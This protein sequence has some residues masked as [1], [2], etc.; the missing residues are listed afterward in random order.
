MEEQQ[1]KTPQ[2]VIKNKGNVIKTRDDRE[3]ILIDFNG[4]VV[5]PEK[6][7]WTPNDGETVSNSVFRSRIEPWLTSLFQSEHLSLLCGSGIT[8]AISFL[9]YGKSGTTMED[10]TFSNYKDEIGAA[11]DASAKASGRE[12]GNME[13]KIR[14]ANDLLRGLKVLGDENAVKLEEELHTIITNFA[15]SLLSSE[16][17]IAISSEDKR[18]NAYRA[19][20]NFLL[21]FASRTGNKERLN[22]FTTNYDRLI[23]VG[24][25]LAGIH[26]MDRFVGTIMPIFRSSRLNLDLHYN[27]PGIRGEPRYLEGVA[28]ITKLHGSLDWVQSGGEIRR[29]GLPFGAANINPYLEAPGLQGADALKLMIYPNSAKD[30]ETAEYPYVELFRDL[31]ASICRPNSTLVTYGYGFGDEHINRVLSDML[32]IPS[33]HLVIISYDDPI[34]RI[35][36]FYSESAHKDQMSILIGANLGDI[37]NLTKDYLPKSAIDRATIRMAELLQNRMGVASNI[38]NPTIPAQIEPST[39]NESATEEIINSES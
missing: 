23:E 21:S 39:T 1:A 29:I 3:L 5:N 35:L 7:S 26:L 25:E 24:A 33:T 2:E 19:L 17:E 4:K 36:K 11:V 16:K 28:R 30:R 34:G 10:I 22:I 38:A 8:N 12:K 14:V 27:P 31:A 18:E 37:T 9:A 32:T 20:I 15:T 6:C 13:D